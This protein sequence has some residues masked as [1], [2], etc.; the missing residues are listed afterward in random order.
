MNN[1][2]KAAVSAVGGYLAAPLVADLVSQM[3]AQ[4][5]DLAPRSDAGMSPRSAWR[6]RMLINVGAQAAV[7]AAIFAALD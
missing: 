3:L 5:D 1:V 4:P 2:S 6:L 7:A